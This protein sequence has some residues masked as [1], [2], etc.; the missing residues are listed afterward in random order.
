MGGIQEFDYY[1]SPAPENREFNLHDAEVMFIMSGTGHGMPPIEYITER[2]PLQHGESLIDYRLRPRLI[3]MVTRRR[4]PCRQ[5]YWDG[6]DDLLDALR[7]NRQAIGQFNP[8]VLRKILPDGSMRDIKV[9]IESGPAFE[10]RAMDRW[11][12]LAFTEILR[13]VAHDP[14][15]FDPMTLVAQWVLAIED[16]LIFYDS[17][18]YTVGPNEILTPSFEV[19]TNADGLADN[20]NI[21][22]APVCAMESTIVLNGCKSQK[23]TTDVVNEGIQSALMAAPAGTTKAVAYAWVCRPAAGSDIRLRMYDDTAAVVKDTQLFST[24]GWQT[25]IV[26]ANTWYRVVVSSSAIV[27]GNNYKLLIDVTAATP[28][29]FYTDMAFWKWGT[30]VCPDD[31]IDNG[32]LGGTIH[33]DRLVFPIWF[34]GIIISAYLNLTYLGTWLS[35]PTIVISGPASNPLIRNVTTDEK[36]ELAYDI[37]AGEVVTFVTEYGNKTITNQWGD[38]LLPYLT[39]DSDLA[40]FH[41]EPDPGAPGGVNQ[42]YVFAAFATPATQVAIYWLRRF[43]GI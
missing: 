3:T 32:I 13:F 17:M 22:G 29:V 15:F 6:R 24:A 39:T 23:V 33:L 10:P 26:G 9:M 41:L 12:E 36:L 37:A 20:W 21:V 7:P 40:T 4:F 8:G 5:D 27:A 14:I 34:T 43:I 11:D 35:Y 2:G 30:I 1:I 16:N 18:D 19:D 25:K 31:W 28:T 38:N 42:M